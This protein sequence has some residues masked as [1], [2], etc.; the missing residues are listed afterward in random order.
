M[1]GPVYTNS[2]FYKCFCTW[3]GIV[4]VATDYTI[5]LL[6]LFPFLHACFCSLKSLSKHIKF[7]VFQ[8]SKRFA[9]L[10]AVLFIFF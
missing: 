4:L 10:Q 3:A 8:F 7:P 2:F 1:E 9:Q 6:A 5:N